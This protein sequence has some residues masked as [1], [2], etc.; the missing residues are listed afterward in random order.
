MINIRQCDMIITLRGLKN[1]AQTRFQ[2]AGFETLW[3]I[4]KFLL[5]DVLNRTNLREW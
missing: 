4:K 5:S 1:S 3:T 2:S